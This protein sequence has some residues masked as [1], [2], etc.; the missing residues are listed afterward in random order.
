[1]TYFKKRR[2]SIMNYITLKQKS[3]NVINAY[4]SVIMRDFIK[5]TQ[6]MAITR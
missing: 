3:N 5:R 2:Y 4:D 6:N 1:M